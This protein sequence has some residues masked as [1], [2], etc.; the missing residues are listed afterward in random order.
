MPSIWKPTCSAS[1]LRNSSFRA[2]RPEHR[3]FLLDH[4]GGRDLA[5]PSRRDCESLAVGIF[6]VISAMLEPRFGR[7]GDPRPISERHDICMGATAQSYPEQ[8]KK[9]CSFHGDLWSTLPLDL[10]SCKPK[11]SYP[12]SQ[13]RILTPPPKTRTN[14]SK[15]AFSEGSLELG[16]WRPQRQRLEAHLA[17]CRK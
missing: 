4:R 14:P 6:I 9:S 7:R 11:E 3:F 2:R 15:S 1:T 13:E 8:Q 17:S 16:A 10:T 5:H 12:K